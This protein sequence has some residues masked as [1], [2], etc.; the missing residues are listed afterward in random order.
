MGK[1]YNGG[2]SFGFSLNF[3]T[4]VPVDTRF[5]VQ[6]I[7][8]LKNPQ[9]WVSGKYDAT[10]DS[11]NV[12]VVYPGL[13]VIVVDEKTIYVFGEGTVNGTT[14]AAD[15]SWTRLATGDNTNDLETAIDKILSS[16]GL[17]T[18]GERPSDSNIPSGSILADIKTL[19]TEVN[20]I[21]EEIGTSADTATDST[22]YGKIAEEKKARE[23]AIAALDSDFDKSDTGGFVNLKIKQENGV[24]TSVA[25]A[26]SDIAKESSITG[27]DTLG[28]AS[29]WAFTA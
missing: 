11:N 24:I 2:A 10:T 18:N 4:A 6:S 21:K 1:L 5:V 16:I 19:E 27:S 13:N 26:T 25:V 17:D 12:Y 29:L 9:T 3:N 14:I 8:D 7:A 20:G 22:I 28:K 23:D 15:S